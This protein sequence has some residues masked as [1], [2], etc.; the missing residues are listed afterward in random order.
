MT[1]AVSQESGMAASVN[2]GFLLRLTTPLQLRAAHTGF[3]T[4]TDIV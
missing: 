3:L 4:E 2:S 1:V